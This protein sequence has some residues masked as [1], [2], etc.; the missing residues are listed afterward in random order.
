MLLQQLSRERLDIETGEE[1]D[2]VVMDEP[3]FESEKDN[4]KVGFMN[5]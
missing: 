3:K 4:S 2:K 1:F 5:L